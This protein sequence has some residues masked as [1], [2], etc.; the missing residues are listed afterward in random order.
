MLIVPLGASSDEAAGR[1]GFA[2]RE[3][4]ERTGRFE[5][6]QLVDV[7]D[8][9]E[10][11]VRERHVEVGEKALASARAAYDQ[12]DTVKAFAET[13]KAMLAFEQTDLSRR[14]QSLTGAWILKIASLVA[15]GE[16]RAAQLEI[17]RLLAVAPEAT[18]SPNYFPPD[19]IAF[20]E[21]A[22]TAARKGDAELEVTTIPSGAEVH[23]D[24]SFRGVSPVT[25]TGLA[26]GEHYV[27]A[28]AAGYALV[29]QKSGPGVIAL[30]LKEAEQWPRYQGVLQEIT[31]DPFGPGRDQ[32]AATFGKSLGVDQLFIGIVERAPGASRAHVTFL[33]L[34]VE[35]GHNFAHAQASVAL[36]DSLLRE[37]G[38]L[39]ARMLVTD[40]PRRGG[41]VTHFTG[42]GRGFFTRKNTGY[43]LLGT[44]AAL[45]AGGIVFGL[46]ASSEAETL[47]GLPQPDPRAAELR[48]S[49]PGYA[50]MA[51]LSFLVGLAAAGTGGFLAFI[52]ASGAVKQP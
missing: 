2:V 3:A 11:K 46:R 16:T 52:P 41:P 49:G 51:D 36:D 45:L 9:E 31:R 30:T 17:R 38:A 44:G 32:A 15:N 7:L 43:L 28:R 26:P 40:D 27:T 6:I 8:A 19:E 12:L 21:A 37:T 10:A 1:I 14:L 23:V 22:R 48:V 42:S 50:L 18:F 39:A 13:R 5:Q 20:A 24:G 34:D 35:D 33:R 47:R 25:V 29:Q 4:I